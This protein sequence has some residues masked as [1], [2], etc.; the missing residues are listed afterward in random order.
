MVKTELINEYF[1]QISIGAIKLGPQKLQKTDS[2]SWE[3]KNAYKE[4]NKFLYH[5]GLSFVLKAIQIELIGYHY[6]NPLASQLRI[7]KTCKF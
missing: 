2:E 3:K 4:I 7:K 1:Y 6:A 5:H